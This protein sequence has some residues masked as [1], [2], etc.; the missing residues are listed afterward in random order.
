MSL[1]RYS[2]LRPVINSHSQ[3]VAFRIMSSA[4]TSV[5]AA[6]GGESVFLRFVTLVNHERSTESLYLLTIR[7]NVLEVITYLRID[8]VFTYSITKI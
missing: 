3:R 2:E 4:L 5:S 6:G 8:H 7:L 1:L